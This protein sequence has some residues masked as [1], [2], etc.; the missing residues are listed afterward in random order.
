MTEFSLSPNSKP[1]RDYHVTLTAIT[2]QGAYNEGAVRD[3]FAG[4]L[5]EVGKKNGLTLLAEQTIGRKNGRIRVDGVLNDSNR[6]PFG[7]WEAKDTRDDLET[8]IAKKIGKDYPL[9]NIIFEDTRQAVL[10]QNKRRVGAYDLTSPAEVAQLLTLFFNHTEPAIDGF[11]DA[12]RIFNERVPEHAQQLRDIIAQAHRENKKFQ[13]AFDGFMAVVR[14]SLNPALSSDEVDEMLI[15][16]LLT[17]RII[18][19]VFD[20]PEF[21]QRNIIAIEVEKVIIALTSRHFNKTEFLGKLDFFYKAIENAARTLDG[22]TEK[23]AFLK[24]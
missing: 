8:E 11:N 14:E 17:E 1:V 22:F 2:G 6:Y 21:T 4:L 13:A 19:N 12:V 20:L 16:H 23:Q 3:A 18:R 15:Q 7:Y 24:S 10:Y 9:Q 5:R